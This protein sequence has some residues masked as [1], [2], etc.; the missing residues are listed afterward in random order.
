ML[1]LSVINQ[2][3]QRL[4]AAAHDP[5]K[6]IL[7][8]SYARGDAGEDAVFCER[9]RMILEPMTKSDAVAASKSGA[10]SLPLRP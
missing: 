10:S 7:L 6:V 4:I 2:A 5:V 9:L 3:V 8:G 1:D